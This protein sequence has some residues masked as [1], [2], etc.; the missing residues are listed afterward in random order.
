MLFYLAALNLL[1]TFFDFTNAGDGSLGVILGLDKL[2]ESAPN[3]F[4]RL[5][6]LLQLI[7]QQWIAFKLFFEQAYGGVAD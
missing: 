2:A 7:K 5:D 3:A 1:N 6:L 4:L